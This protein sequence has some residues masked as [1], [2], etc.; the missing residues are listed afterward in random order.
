MPLSPLLLLLQ[1]QSGCLGKG[2]MARSKLSACLVRGACT[3]HVVAVEWDLLTQWQLW[4]GGKDHSGEWEGSGCSN[5]E[6]GLAHSGGEVPAVVTG[7]AAG[8][9]YAAV[10][11]HIVVGRAQEH[12]KHAASVAYSLHGVWS[13]SMASVVCGPCPYW[14][15]MTLA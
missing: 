15:W 5:W 11:L 13:G 14:I 7:G 6:R 10:G 8:A 3:A 9:A 12:T 2:N 1:Q 4:R